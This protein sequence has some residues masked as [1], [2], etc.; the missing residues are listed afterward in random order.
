MLTELSCRSAKA[1]GKAVKLADAGGLFL[2]VAPTGLKSWRMKYRFAGKEKK[3]TIGRYPEVSLKEARAARDI[4]KAQLHSG[5]DPAQE[6]QRKR[7]EAMTSAQNS[8]SAIAEEWMA[9]KTPTLTPRYAKRVRERLTNATSAFGNLPISDITP[10][11]VL[12]CVRA[13]QDRGARSMAM[14][15]LQICSSVF[16]FSIA[17]GRSDQNPAEA[18]RGVLSGTV[19]TRRPAQLTLKSARVTLE[20]IEQSEDTWWAAV[21]ASRL[22]ALTAQ[23]PGV[24]R[25]AEKKEF[26]QLNSKEPRWRIP[27]EKMKLK[28]ER[29]SDEAFDFIVPLSRQAVDLVKCTLETSPSPQWLFPGRA[30]WRKPINENA[31]SDLY[32]AVGLTNQQVPHG[33]RASF[34][35]I[36]NEWAAENGRELDRSI[37]DM[38]LAH[39]SDTVEAAYNRAAY[40]PR[41]REIAQLWADM[42][43]DGLPPP[44]TL[45]PATMG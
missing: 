36:M 10:M 33:W 26:E 1:E 21:M 39:M 29:K 7:Q 9:T 24:V 40:M 22:T 41:R 12:S 11:M 42:L 37:I 8:F 13:I 38:M 32:R 43:L 35:T 4:A 2:F 15:V 6:K 45:L 27:A 31:L 28:L 44:E 14:R 3:L 17:T 30:G 19:K 16:A 23:R 34:S 25:M 18:I 20:R 5:V